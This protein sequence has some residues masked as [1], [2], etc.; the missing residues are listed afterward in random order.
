ME[1][2]QQRSLGCKAC[3]I[4]PGLRVLPG[5]KRLIHAYLRTCPVHAVVYMLPCAFPVHALPRYSPV[6]ISCAC[7]VE[8]QHACT[9]CTLPHLCR[10]SVPP[11][12][13]VA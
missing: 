12:G 11:R 8:A 7:Y 2:G 5:P 6:C 10:K 13:L 1:Q 9:A 3:D 4:G